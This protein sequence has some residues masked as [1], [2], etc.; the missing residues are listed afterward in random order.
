MSMCNLK[1]DDGSLPPHPA[2][3]QIGAS[4]ARLMFK[5]RGNHS[6]VHLTEPE[7]ATLCIGAADMALRIA[8]RHGLPVPADGALQSQ[9]NASPAGKEK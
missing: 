6:E 5:A 8:E 4:L 3:E 2:A 1:V 9:T 7:L